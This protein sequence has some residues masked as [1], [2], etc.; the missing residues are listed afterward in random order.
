MP[1]P[2]LSPFYKVRPCSSIGS[3]SE[4][5]CSKT[6]QRK[7]SLAKMINLQTTKDSSWWR[8]SSQVST[9]SHNKAP[10]TWVWTDI[11]LKWPRCFFF[12]GPHLWHMQMPRLGVKSELQLPA[13][14]TATAT[15]DPGCI[16]SLCRSSSQ[17]W[18]LNPLSKA[19]D[20]THILTDTYVRFLTHGAAMETPV[21]TILQTL[22]LSL[23]WPTR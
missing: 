21:A 6:D 13:Y 19:R 1:F 14:P 15:P 8:I 22:F 16:C 17:H 9:I 7:G 4:A 10:W 18:I 2:T 5:R 12:L 3:W 20:W 11:F 23:H